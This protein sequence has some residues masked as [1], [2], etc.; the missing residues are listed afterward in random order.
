MSI[1]AMRGLGEKNCSR[2]GYNIYRHIYKQGITCT[3][4]HT[5]FQSYCIFN[6]SENAVIFAD[7]SVLSLSSC[8]LRLY[9]QFWTVKCV[10]FFLCLKTRK[11]P[12]TLKLMNN[13]MTGYKFIQKIISSLVLER[14]SS[15][16]MKPVP[17]LKNTSQL[18]V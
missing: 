18:L 15:E 10:N 12:Q 8:L 13:L 11:K 7:L 16:R 4:K 14:T 5:L 3:E 17:T 6:I 1:E 9:E 2:T